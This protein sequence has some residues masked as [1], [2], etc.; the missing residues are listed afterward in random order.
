MA[1]K[2][3]E[4]AFFQ[5]QAMEADS[6]NAASTEDQAADNDDEEEEEEY[7]P[8]KTLDDQ[9]EVAEYPQ[10][11]E[12]DPAVPN[13]IAT[14]D[15]DTGAADDLPNSSQNPSRAESQ[16]STPLPP[17]GATSQPQTRTIGGFVV[18]DDEDED[19]KDEADY[20]PPAALGVDDANAMPMTMSED[21]SSGNANQN[22]S[23]D[24]SHQEGAAAVP[25]LA[26]SS[27]SHVPVPNT[28]SSASGQ[29]SWTG[30]AI[31]ASHQSS[32]VPTPVPDE[33]AAGRSRLP[34]DRVGILQDRVDEDPR[35]DLSAWLE[36][37][38]EHRGRNRLDSAREVYE[39][40]LKVFP[41][42]VSFTF[43]KSIKR[44]KCTN[45]WTT[46]GSMGSLC[47]NG[48]RT[49]RTLPPRTDIQSNPSYHPQCE[50]LVG[51]SR[52]CSSPQPFNHRYHR[53]SETSH[54]IG[55]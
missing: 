34:H 30:A 6:D 51:I 45:R 43:T 4:Q 55:I 1:D 15:V 10:E 41:M 54:L 52:L 13:P 23:Q 47:D 17:A 37:I 46:G 32:T 3:A 21:P 29:A 8:S 28:D 44:I 35:G 12:D 50:P 14:E 11:D 24:V 16:S 25:D 5:A 40:F 27:Y 19:E 48:I 39:Q 36:L 2:E 49:Q 18:E 9:Y 7:D 53:T 26:N 38:A 31:D 20:E 33:P 42:A 22:T